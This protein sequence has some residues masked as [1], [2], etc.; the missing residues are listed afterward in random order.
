MSVP[1]KRKPAKRATTKPD[2][3]PRAPKPAVTQAEAIAE[4][5][6]RIAVTGA[7][8][9]RVA[10]LRSS[11]LSLVTLFGE[12][13]DDEVLIPLIDWQLFGRR[14]L[15]VALD[16]EEIGEEL[17]SHLVAF[18]NMAFILSRIGQDLCN[19]VRHLVA[20]SHGGIVPIRSR[21]DY[22]ARTLQRAAELM[23]SAAAELRSGLLEEESASDTIE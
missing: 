18:D 5:E 13:D 6:A 12:M 9:D 2:K 11:T 8:P 10:Q 4:P 22:T 7:V 3:A 1:V 17:A 14:E 23:L 21:T 16:D 19:A 20:Q 15:S